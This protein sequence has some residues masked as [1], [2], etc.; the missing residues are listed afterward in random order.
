MTAATMAK[1]HGS[2]L[3]VNEETDIKV[4]LAK[5]NMR[6]LQQCNLYGLRQITQFY[7]L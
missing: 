1:D 3:Y 4:R 2:T 5:N 7:I 6:V